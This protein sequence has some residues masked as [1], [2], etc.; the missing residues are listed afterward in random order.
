MYT[1]PAFVQWKPA[2]SKTTTN[3][4][5]E[6]VFEY[7]THFAHSALELF[8]AAFSTWAEISGSQAYRKQNKVNSSKFTCCQKA[9]KLVYT[10]TQPRYLFQF[11][12]TRRSECVQTKTNMCNMSTLYQATGNQTS[13]SAIAERPRCRVG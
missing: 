3:W 4:L 12:H 7:A 6:D 8:C 13:S 2:V 1:Q 5:T 11:T 10:A 9:V